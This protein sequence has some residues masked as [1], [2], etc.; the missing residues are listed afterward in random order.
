LLF[1]IAFSLPMA[2]YCLFLTIKF[3]VSFMHQHFGLKEQV[4]LKLYIFQVKILSEFNKGFH[5]KIEVHLFQ[6]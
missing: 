6:R 2:K 5:I 1:R 4:P 3:F